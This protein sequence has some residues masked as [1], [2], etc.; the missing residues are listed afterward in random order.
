MTGA[1]L[2]NYLDDLRE[3]GVPAIRPRDPEASWWIT[4]YPNGEGCTFDTKNMGSREAWLL[5]GF[6]VEHAKERGLRRSVLEHPGGIMVH[7][8]DNAEQ[9]T[10]HAE[11][12]LEA[13]LKAY[14][15]VLEAA[16]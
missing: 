9:G 13:T 16:A 8:F 2:A 14:L 4:R 5:I 1:E 10:G 12:E 11:T 3:A 15:K 7:F 6:V